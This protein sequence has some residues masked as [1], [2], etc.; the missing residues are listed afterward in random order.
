MGKHP[1]KR[2]KTNA[3]SMPLG[4]GDNARLEMLLDDESKDDEERRLESMLF[5]VKYVPR[6]KGKS[7]E[8]DDGEEGGDALDF[9]GRGMDHLLDNDL[10][11]VD[12]GADEQPI[13][14]SVDSD[15]D[16][17]QS[18]DEDNSASSSSD[19]E[20]STSQPS[21]ANITSKS[22][23]KPPA[24]TD[25]T[26][27][28]PN[29]SVSLLS[30]PT[31][32]RKLRQGPDEDTITGREYE[33]RLRQQFERINPEPAWAKKAR[34]IRRGDVDA[35]DE[36]EANDIFSSTSGI[37]KKKDTG[38]VV[39][40]QGQL[41]IERLR[42]ANQAV[43]GSG[44]GEVRVLAFHPSPAVPVLCVASADRR[45][46]LFN[47]DG[48]LN[49]LLTTLHLPNLPLTSPTSALFHPRGTSI[50]LSGPRPFFYTYDLQTGTSA[51]HA[52]GLWGTT[53]GSIS[54]NTSSVSSRRKRGSGSTADKGEAMSLTAFSPSGELLAVA[55]RNGY[56][57]LVDWKSG[58]GQVI[59]SLKCASSGGGGGIHG[60]WWNAAGSDDHLTVLT[61]DAEV[62]LWDVGQRRCVRRWKDEGGF[63]GAGRALAGTAAGNGYLAVGAN[64]G[65]VNLYGSES[66]SS[67]GFNLNAN[68]KPVKTI[69]NLTTAISTLRFN[70][71]AQILAVA[72]KEKKDSMR[73]IHLP[74][75]TSFSNWPTSST[76][77][78]HV[79]A[80]DF[81]A[82][83]EY[84]AIGNTKGRVLLYHLK[85]YGAPTAER[86]G[87]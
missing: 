10:F 80:I 40:K 3:S 2:Q 8:P 55:G 19:S 52:R 39:L 47:V 4:D 72:S 22:K 83:S 59:D 14:P 26:D 32:L 69:G 62:Y 57:H 49:P 27:V 70:H 12:D 33:T 50:L 82:R 42:D 67:D 17:D 16:E 41:S 9:G 31:R 76:P 11:F 64:T 75:A 25:P 45:V 65:F 79:S 1:R 21:L 54:D 7:K 68:P 35:S 66:F 34:K 73:M 37:L 74:T 28:N 58:A 5:G 71:D 46:R 15:G 48:H 87:F 86:W 6:G 18:D 23:R 38:K 24:W 36:E 43:Q 81:S 61:G 85:E 60:V 56:I 30:G 29:S 44:N 78:G 51:H 84:V 20:A 63:R 77:L 53:F 13:M